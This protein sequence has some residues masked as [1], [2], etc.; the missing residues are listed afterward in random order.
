MKYNARDA[1]QFLFV[2]V[3]TSVIGFGAG[4]ARGH[5]ADPGKLGAP[6]PTSAVCKAANW[7]EPVN[8]TT[9]GAS[10]D[11]VCVHGNGVVTWKAR[12]GTFTIL[13][14]NSPWGGSATYP[15]SE[16]APVAKSRPFPACT[17]STPCNYKYTL[18][19]NGKTIDPHVIIVP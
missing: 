3:C 14:S 17:S 2:L 19:I 13:F 6:S 12:A 7:K 8:V 9:R 15:S 10:P 11:P 18:K 1:M 16:T 4:S 5:A